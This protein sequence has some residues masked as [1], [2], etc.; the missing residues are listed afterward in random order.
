MRHW[1][2][3]NHWFLAVVDTRK[4]EIRY[5]D[6]LPITAYERYEEWSKAIHAYLR[7]KARSASEGRSPQHHPVLQRTTDQ[8]NWSKVETQQ[9]I[10]SY[11]CGYHLLV[12]LGRV[13]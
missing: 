13:M 4:L 10:N 8:L 6:S 9:Q 11:D 3:D 12:T 1:D 7:A 2:D 5:F